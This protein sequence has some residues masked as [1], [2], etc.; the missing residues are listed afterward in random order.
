MSRDL[1]VLIFPAGTGVSKE[2]FDALKYIRNIHLI[3]A[4]AD[5][6]NFSSY[7]FECL[8]LGAPFI[9]DAAATIAYLKDI[10]HKHRIDCIY[11]AFD[12]IITFLKI[13][14]ETLGVKVIAS[15]LET[16]R[17]CF[18]KRLTYDFFR[19]DLVVP[20]IVDASGATAFPLFLKPECGYGARDSF[21]IRNVRELAFYD[22][23]V[24]DNILCEYLPGDEYT[25]DCFSSIEH[26][27][28]FC[29]ARQRMKTVNGLS[30]LTEHVDLPIVKQIGEVI[31]A[32]LRFIG[33]WFFQVKYNR[34][35]RL[36]LLEIAPRIPGAAALHRN[37]GIN[38]PLL[39]I[40]EHMGQSVDRVLINDYR[41]SCYKCV[42]NRFRLSLTYDRAYV[43]LDDTII[44]K[45]KV[46]TKM[47]Q[48][49][50]Y[51]R[52]RGTSIVLLT[53]N[54][55]PHACL[56]RFF[57]HDALFDRIIVVDDHEKKS[58]YISGTVPSI[59]I[60]DSFNERSDV[61]TVNKIPVFSCD[62]VEALFD[63]KL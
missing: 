53:R 11:P 29:E 8:E 9:K 50:Y 51:L 59:F 32:K 18:S 34:E 26:G 22:A 56:E 3:G 25:V 43:D 12:S 30:V 40:H 54:R 36:C 39:S 15:P 1:N 28:I 60:D 19:G 45:N 44:L 10:V 2:I 7:Q 21:K 23:Q 4:D 48:Y 61:F 37:K 57:I 41:I 42:E 16:C 6:H 46:N 38:F 35:G 63:E 31:A 14:E 17:I 47:V 27:L 20:A 33:A 52:N 13:H 5:E 55:D 62:M 24:A 58:D 49:L